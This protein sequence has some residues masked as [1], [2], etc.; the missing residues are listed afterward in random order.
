[1]FR[2]LA[3]VIVLISAF[4]IG[5]FLMGQYFLEDEKP[6]V[7]DK[8]IPQTLDSRAMDELMAKDLALTTSMFLSQLSNQL[9][10]WGEYDLNNEEYHTV[11]KEELNEHPHFHGFAIFNGDSITIQEGQLSTTDR[12]LLTHTHMLSEFSDPFEREGT[13]Y[14]LMGEQ[15]ADGRTLLGEVDLTFVKSYVKDLASVADSNG[16]FFVSGENPDIQ[17]QTMNDVP[18]GYKAEHVPELGW[19][20]VVHSDQKKSE[21]EQRTYIEHQAVIKFKDN[22]RSLNWIDE[23]QDLTFIESSGPFLVVQSD[24]FTTEELINRLNN[25]ADLVFIEPNYLMTNQVRIASTV[26]NDEFFQPYQWNL[27]QINISN[28]WDLSGGENIMIAILDTGVDENH[29]DLQGKINKGYNAFSENGDF[30]DAHGHGTHVAG[31]ASATT[32]NITG[33]AGVSWK[34][35]ILPVKVL[36]DEGEGS[37]YEVAN[38]IYWAVDQGA[39]VINM[40]LGDYY[41]SDALYDAIQYAYEKDVVLIAASGNDNVSDPLYP[42]YYPEVLTVA[43]VDQDKNRAF[44]SNYGEHV[45][46]SAPGEHIPS[47]FPDNNYTVMSGTSMAAPHVAGLAGLIRALRP[48]LSNQQ[49]YDTITSTANDLGDNGKDPYYGYGEMD[50]AKALQSI[51]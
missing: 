24:S 1:M 42:A 14:M 25:D 15:I 30:A 2:K 11:F 43:A 17:W 23:H 10:R 49:V 18:S 13:Y 6:Y 44:F 36:N 29:L 27:E 22:Q 45:D 7:L 21:S 31:V 33:I 50:V 8:E 47:L 35:E 4:G 26:P 48:D 32:N 5:M 19:D 20:I 3:I 34:S 46:I 41:H 51:R 37:S 39:D 16:N 40:S 38:G 28:G 9:N 12:S